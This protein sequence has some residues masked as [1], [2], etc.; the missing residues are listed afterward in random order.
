LGIFLIRSPLAT[1]EL[2]MTTSTGFCIF[3]LA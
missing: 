2:F 3:K 1:L